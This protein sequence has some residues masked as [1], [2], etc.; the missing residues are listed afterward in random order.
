ME[1]KRTFLILGAMLF[2]LAACN[3]LLVIQ[4]LR[5]RAALSQYEVKVLA[6]GDQ[7]QPFAAASLDGRRVEVSFDG[8]GP[9]RVLLFF[10]PTCRFCRQQFPYWRELLLRADP[11]RFEIIGVVSQAEDKTKLE[12]YLR[13]VGCLDDSKT[14]MRVALVPEGVRESYKLF[15]TPITLVIANDGKLE[16]VW[17]GSWRPQDLAAAS[18][19]FDVSLSEAAGVNVSSSKLTETE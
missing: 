5:M 3:V 9:K 11:N 8:R 2:A 16:K 19:V 1:K 6:D 17:Y 13:S 10:T 15:S 14:S 12:A 18:A 4:N 7:L